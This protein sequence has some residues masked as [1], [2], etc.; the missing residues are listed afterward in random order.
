VNYTNREVVRRLKQYDMFLNSLNLT[1]DSFQKE[2]ICDQLDKIE[3]QI[4][5]ETNKEYEEQ[6]MLLLSEETKFFADEKDKLR[7]IID[8]IKERRNYLEQ[9]KE[10]HKD[11]TGSL[12][13]LTTFLGED[14]LTVFKKRLQIIEKYEEN[15]IKQENLI[16][17]MKTL[18]IKISEASRNV[19]ANARLNDTLENKMITLIEKTLHKLE[20][21][22]LIDKKEDI[23]RKYDS[24]NY[25]VELAKENLATAKKIENDEMIL[26]CENILSEITIEFLKYNEEKNIIK[27]IDI[28]DKPVSGYNDLL[29]KREK[30]DDIL[31]N[32]V[33]SKLYHEISDELNKQYTSI[34]LQKQDSK[35]Y[36][37]LKNER[38][39]KHNTLYE[40]EEEN[41]S[42]EFRQ[43]LDELIK[44]ENKHKEE[45]IK[46]AKR[47]EYQERQKKLLEEQKIEASRVRRQ[48]LIEQ[49]RLKE[50]EERLKKVKEL[51]DKTVISSQ[52]EES[53]KEIKSTLVGKSLDENIKL[54]DTFDTNELFEKTKIYPNKKEIK[55]DKEKTNNISLVEDI[56]SE[57]SEEKKNIDIPMWNESSN[58]INVTE[59]TIDLFKEEPVEE[60]LVVEL[61]E[62]E[63]NEN[64]KNDNISIYDILENSDNIIWKPTDTKSSNNIPVINNNNLKPE[65]IKD[66]KKGMAFPKL[67]NKEGDILWKETL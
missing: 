20:L 41:N 4:L 47:E 35:N 21:Y 59:N 26:E 19:K 9:R 39:I 25:A 46:K 10:K 33:D 49:A 56:K 18:D 24:L 27:L 7:K 48:K 16:K 58:N 52:K 15:K 31:K 8:L 17:E 42:K 2:R 13:E 43:V 50:Q 62:P 22:D 5:L 1:V 40:I 28:F 67:D 34:K 12:V 29:A 63:N 61:K 11:I 65:I 55:L 44:N 14:K 6:Y 57:I 38:N 64:S 66:E 3:K 37:N 54:S 32:I 53:L 51:Q 23:E 45:Q 30:I 60:N 36:E